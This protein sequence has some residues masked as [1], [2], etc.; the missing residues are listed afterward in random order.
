MNDRAHVSEPAVPPVFQP[1]D[2]ERLESLATTG[3]GPLRLA[4][5]AVLAADHR[6]SARHAQ[7][8]L[9]QAAVAAPEPQPA[10]AE[11]PPEPQPAPAESMA[12]VPVVARRRAK[13]PGPDV[14]TPA[15]AAPS[16]RNNRSLT[17]AR[18]QRAR[19]DHQA[20]LLG[21]PVDPLQKVADDTAWERW[22]SNLP[23][24]DE[25]DGFERLDGARLGRRLPR[26]GKA[27]AASPVPAAAVS[28]AP[29]APATPVPAAPAA[30]KPSWRSRAGAVLDR[31]AEQEVARGARLEQRLIP[32]SER[33]TRP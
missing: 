8:A 32:T 26:R 21:A 15:P 27:A 31:L 24:P 13:A 7:R 12:P 23:D 20:K 30:G 3:R 5:A 16:R 17:R 9:R 11:P 6:R 1:T 33:S 4:A 28:P 19:S 22:V 14:E 29:A 25:Q 2:E 10:S 18:L